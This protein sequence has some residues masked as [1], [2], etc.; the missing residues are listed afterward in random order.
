MSCASIIV[1][2]DLNAPDFIV[3]VME[4]PTFIDMIDILKCDFYT[5]VELLFTDNHV[6]LYFTEKKTTV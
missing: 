2:G 4:T 6:F 5:H 1:R 3:P